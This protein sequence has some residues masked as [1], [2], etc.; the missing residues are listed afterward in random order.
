MVVNIKKKTEH[1]NHL[2]INGRR[3]VSKRNCTEYVLSYVAGVHVRGRKG[4]E[5][6][7][8]QQWSGDTREYNIR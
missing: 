3:G 8:Q 5:K 6:Q 2:T 1:I 4:V 7:Q